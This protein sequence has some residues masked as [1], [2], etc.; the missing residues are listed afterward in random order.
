MPIGNGVVDVDRAAILSTRRVGRRGDA[1]T[2]DADADERIA[3]D[4]LILEPLQLSHADE[5]VAVLA[6]DR[7]YEFTGGDAP[8]FDVL[9]GRYRPGRADTRS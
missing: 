1:G 7:V 2:A 4:R 9:V 5:M 8:T 3:T 6:D